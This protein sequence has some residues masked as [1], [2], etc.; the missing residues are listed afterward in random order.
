MRGGGPPI[1]GIK[2]KCP[3][4]EIGVKGIYFKSYGPRPNSSNFNILNPRFS[5]F[6]PL[7][8][9]RPRGM[10]S[11]SILCF[12]LELPKVYSN[13]LKVFHIQIVL[14]GHLVRTAVHFLDLDH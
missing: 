5:S 10:Y 1:L 14:L 11:N 4:G 8:G 9:F 6:S 12:I 3:N 13:L 7:D 2:S